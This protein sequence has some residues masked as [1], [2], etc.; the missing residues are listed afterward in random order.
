MN[1][2]TGPEG[3]GAAAAN[4]HGDPVS[5]TDFENP[6]ASETCEGDACFIEYVRSNEFVKIG[7]DERGALGPASCGSKGMPYAERLYPLIG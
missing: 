2:Y 4:M 5:G 1:V 6:P 3:V 7:V